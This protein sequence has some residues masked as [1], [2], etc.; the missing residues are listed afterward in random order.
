MNA[1][2]DPRREVLVLMATPAKGPALAIF[3][4]LTAGVDG[5]SLVMRG[6]VEATV[7]P[8]KTREAAISAAMGFRT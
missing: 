2:P 7:G 6:V 1:P 4:E 5:W 8:M 3:V